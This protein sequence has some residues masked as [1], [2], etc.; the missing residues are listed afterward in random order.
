MF[1][2]GSDLLCF[3]AK[4]GVSGAHPELLTAFANTS[5]DQNNT[6]NCFLNETTLAAVE[7]LQMQDAMSSYSTH[8]RILWEL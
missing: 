6:F 3:R 2:Q 4:R 7:S 5:P 1:A 8:S